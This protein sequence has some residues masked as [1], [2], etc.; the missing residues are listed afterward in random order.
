LT[1]GINHLICASLAGAMRWRAPA[2]DMCALSQ[3]AR[4][5]QIEEGW[6]RMFR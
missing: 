2:L 5:R 6:A 3:E 4:E 1:P